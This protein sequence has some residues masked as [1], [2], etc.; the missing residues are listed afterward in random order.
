M[1]QAGSCDAGIPF[2]N[3]RLWIYI[4][5][6]CPQSYQWEWWTSQ[7]T[8]ATHTYFLTKYTSLGQPANFSRNTTT[9]KIPVMKEMSLKKKDPGNQPWDY[10]H[11]T[12]FHTQKEP[13]LFGVPV[14]SNFTYSPPTD[15]IFPT[16]L[17]MTACDSSSRGPDALCWAL[18]AMH[19]HDAYTYMWATHLHVN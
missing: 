19:S 14:Y 1:S 2:T 4:R 7:A 12:C 11:N 3:P 15:S 18:W 5:G 8:K 6:C 16:G 13:V 10:F 17:V 9:R